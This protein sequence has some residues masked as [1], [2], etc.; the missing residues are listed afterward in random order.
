LQTTRTAKTHLQAEAAARGICEQRLVF[1]PALAQESHLGRLQLADLALDTFPVTSHTTASDALWAGVPLLTFPGETFVSRVAASVLTAGGL[2]ELVA[3]NEDAYFQL[4]EELATTP[5]KLR[6]LRVQVA[7]NR[8]R[9]PLFDS[10]Q[11]VRDLEAL[12][13]RAWAD[14]LKGRLEPFALKADKI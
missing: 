8:D 14:H 11:F 5:A 2:P 9:S 1:A 3:E 4:A 10:A 6:E 7:H 12:Y 13:E